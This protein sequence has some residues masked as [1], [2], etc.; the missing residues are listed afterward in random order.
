MMAKLSDTQRKILENFAGRDPPHRPSGRS[1]SG[2]WS[3][4]IVACYRNGWLRDGKITEEGRA[5]LKQEAGGE[6]PS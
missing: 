2:G 6:S 5:A 3:G 1:Q 4:A